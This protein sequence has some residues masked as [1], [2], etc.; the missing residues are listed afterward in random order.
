[1]RPVLPRRTA[2]AAVGYI[3]AVAMLGTTLPTPFYPVYHAEMHSS[4]LMVTVIFATYAAGVLASLVAAGRISDQ[5]GR[6]PAL[7]AGLT[8]SALSAVVFQHAGAVAPLLAGRFLSGISAGLFTGTATAAL[9]DLAAPE[10][11]GRTT[12]IATT[13]NLAG[14]GS[15]PL[16]AG[17]LARLTSMPLEI[18]V[19]DRPGAPGPGLRAGAGHA[20][21][22]AGPAGG[23]CAAGSPPGPA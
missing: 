16:L 8:F 11:R 5:I 19:L 20:R 21:D 18:P 2:M 13:S 12:L 9:T 23:P 17:L 6:R 15:G 1:M 10:S 4:D 22:S 3:F 7:L 14:L